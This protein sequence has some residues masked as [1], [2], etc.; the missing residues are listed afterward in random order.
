M[1]GQP[2]WHQS[3]VPK[4][5]DF[6]PSQP[7]HVMNA[8]HPSLDKSSYASMGE[9]SFP[10]MPMSGYNP[11]GSSG[12]ST[13]SR[14]SGFG[15]SAQQYQTSSTAGYSNQNIYPP[16]PAAPAG[17]AGVSSTGTGQTFQ[18]NEFSTAPAQPHGNTSNNGA[19]YYNSGHYAGQYPW[20]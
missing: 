16:S 12:T 9:A 14:V 15:S 8:R 4:A 18:A 10:T 3:H 11:Y 20:I 2:V 19:G 17:S 1:N 7:M 6:L 13:S 5:P